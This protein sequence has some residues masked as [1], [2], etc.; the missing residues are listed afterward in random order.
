MVLINLNG[1]VV[2]CTKGTKLR[3]DMTICNPTWERIFN[4]SCAICKQSV[5]YEQ[6]E[7]CHK[8][9]IV[10]HRTCLQMWC[11]IKKNCPGCRASLRKCSICHKTGHNKSKCT[12]SDIGEDADYDVNTM[13]DTYL[14]WD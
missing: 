1:E 8:C 11:N 14:R 5:D 7:K 12:L 9:T 6:R 3:Y 2:S 10:L 13:G 4:E